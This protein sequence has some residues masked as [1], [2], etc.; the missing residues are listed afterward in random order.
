MPRTINIP[1]GSL[2]VMSG[3]PGSGKSTFLSRSNLAPGIVQSTDAFRR[4]IGGEQVYYGRDAQSQSYQIVDPENALNVTVWKVLMRVVEARLAQGMTT[5]VDATLVADYVQD[6]AGRAMF[7]EM[8]R[9]A[10]VPF[11]VLMMDTATEVSAAR[12]A[13]RAARVSDSRMR[14]ME[15]NWQA[16]SMFPYE[17]VQA[18]DTLKIVAPLRIDTD[19]VDIVGDVHG[20]YSDLLALLAALG[21]DAYGDGLYA[22]PQGRKLLFMGDIVDRGPSSVA[23]LGFVSRMVAAG[24][25]WCLMG[26]HEDKLLRAW[27][28]MA[29]GSLSTW[30]S[31]ANAQTLMDL[32][33]TE[34]KERN[35]EALIAFMRTLPTFA[36]YESDDSVVFFAHADAKSI[37]VQATPKEML[38]YGSSNFGQF[39]AD[40]SMSEYLV[41]HDAFGNPGSEGSHKPARRQVYVHGHVPISGGGRWPNVL[42]LDNHCF[43]GGSILAL[44]LDAYLERREGWLVGRPTHWDYIP[45]ENAR[46]APYRRLKSLV[47]KELVRSTP[48]GAT[49]LT[50]FKYAK[51]VFYDRRWGEDPMLLRA[52]GHVYDVAGNLVSNPFDKVFN[53]GEPGMDGSAT[54]TRTDDA[55]PV[56]AVEKLNGFLGVVS[57][58]PVRY[59]GPK[60]LVHSS[61]SFD[62]KFVGYIRDYL[63]PQVSGPLAAFLSRKPMTL[64]FEVLHPED[65]HIIVYGA[66]NYG[67]HLIGARA[68][69]QGSPLMREDELDAL[70][71]QLGLRRPSWTRTTFGDLKV[72]AASGLGEGFMVRTDDGAQS[73]L[74]K[75]KTPYYLTTKFLSRMNDG[76][77]KF[78]FANPTAFKKNVDEEFF[79]LVDEIT[80]SMCLDDVLCL[81]EIER[82]DLVGGMVLEALGPVDRETRQAVSCRP[83]SD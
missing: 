33:G 57:P 77:W 83:T 19:K 47:N 44:R 2:A 10:G 37:N 5:I 28:Q 32:A 46:V 81:G 13:A 76:K 3:I 72:A 48:E 75:L 43:S 18:D 22:H 59:Q 45:G 7:A 38:L 52:R 71:G 29:V 74:F 50:L 70:A 20:M 26:N 61:G 63:P 21:Y 25:A 15:E 16:D 1:S 30:K 8:A 51:S 58:H 27:D 23:T 17:K 64:M 35:I 79:G 54:G 41:N 24:Q 55:T 73:T 11:R 62:S 67:L 39:D 68:I 78:M 65:P 66:Q 12:N 49:G 31:Y 34:P 4:T 40:A 56:V 14:S 6:S 82:R 36:T 53:L 69:E 42:S 80:Q 9:K 60:L